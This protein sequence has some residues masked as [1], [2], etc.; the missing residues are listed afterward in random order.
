MSHTHRIVGSSRHVVEGARRARHAVNPL[1]Q[2]T[3]RGLSRSQ[4]LVVEDGD[5]GGEDGAGGG[6]TSHFQKHA[7]RR[8]TVPVGLARERRHVRIAAAGCVVVFRRGQ[9][10]A[11]R[12]VRGHGILLVV[13]NGERI[14]EATCS[15]VRV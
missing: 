7:S 4:Q 12:E 3:H 14:G 9:S 6:G 11:A 15:G 2:E 5:V 8:N 13:G 1:V 10:D